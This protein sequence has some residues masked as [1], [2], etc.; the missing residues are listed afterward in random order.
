MDSRTL[1]FLALVACAG[2][3]PKVD[4]VSVAAGPPGMQR[5]SLTLHNERRH[6]EV[7]LQITLHDAAGHRIKASHTV[8]IEAHE[9]LHLWVDVPAPSGVYVAEVKPEYPD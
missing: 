3:Q 8:E 5:V 9:T 7:D 6:G 4:A 2:P 1:V